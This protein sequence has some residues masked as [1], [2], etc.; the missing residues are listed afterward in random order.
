PLHDLERNGPNLQYTVWW[1]R[2]DSG[3]DWTNVTTFQSK[4]IFHPTETYVPYEIKIQARNDFGSG[5]ESNI[6]TGFSGEDKPREAPSELRVSKVGSTT[7]NI[8]WKPVDL[9][10]VQ[11]EF[12][13][14]R[15]Y[16]YRESSLVPRLVVSKEKKTTGFYTTVPEPSGIVK[17]LMPYSRYQMFM[18]VANNRFESTPSN[19]VEF[20]TEEDGEDTPKNKPHA[21]VPR[22]SD[23]Q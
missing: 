6:V 19:T 2:K 8:H 15:L 18:V 1:R 3:D 10:S 5:P 20:T 17:D 12:K 9:S 11:G 21:R 14:Y 22:E 23:I 16:Y 4:Y 7:A 13:E